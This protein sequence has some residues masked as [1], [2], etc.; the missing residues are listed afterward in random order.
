MLQCIW[1]DIWSLARWST[2]WR[3]KS[4]IFSAEVCRHSQ[5][6]LSKSF[7]Q[8]STWY[9]YLLLLNFIKIVLNLHQFFV[10]LQLALW[11]GFWF[12]RWRMFSSRKFWIVQMLVVVLS[13]VGLVMSRL[14][15]SNLGCWQYLHPN[16]I[17]ENLKLC[18]DKM[19]NICDIMSLTYHSF[20]LKAIKPFAS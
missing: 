14:I 18:F 20:T 10:T 11:F 1:F 4:T 15:D 19:L 6:Q 9:F 13:W 5:C 17:F 16:I 2:D 7:Q 12:G 3:A 8:V